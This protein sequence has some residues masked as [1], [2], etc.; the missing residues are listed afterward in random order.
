MTETILDAAYFVE[1]SKEYE[2]IPLELIDDTPITIRRAN[3]WVETRDGVELGHPSRLHRRDMNNADDTD[4]NNC[5]IEL[6]VGLMK[7]V[8][9]E[10]HRGFIFFKGI[11]DQVV[12]EYC[13]FKYLNIPVDIH[14]LGGGGDMQA[15]YNLFNEMML[16]FSPHRSQKQKVRIYFHSAVSAGCFLFGLLIS[17]GFEVYVPKKFLLWVHPIQRITSAVTEVDVNDF[18]FEVKRVL[19]QLTI[20]DEWICSPWT[21]SYWIRL[22]TIMEDMTY[23]HATT[24]VPYVCDI[25]QRKNEEGDFDHVLYNK[26]ISIIRRLSR[27]Q[28]HR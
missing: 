23:S 7:P 13:N 12:I 15:M 20:S 19:Y 2:L 11:T 9:G 25:E 10:K 28:S 6:E 16:G 21:L 18:R 27:G 8:E 17:R 26:R 4:H 3:V 1:K 14:I 5:K 22:F 24:H